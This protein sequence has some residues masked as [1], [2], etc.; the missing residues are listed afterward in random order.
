MRAAGCTRCAHVSSP[1]STARD[2][3]R[4][5]AKASASCLPASRTSAR[6]RCSTRSPEPNSPSSRPI[7]GTTRDKISETIQIDG[8]PLH[9][10]DTAGLREGGDEVERIG[11]ERSWH[12]IEGADAVVLL[13][14]L[15]RRG[16]PA[17]SMPT[18]ASASASPRSPAVRAP[19]LDVW[20]KADIAA[21]P[22]DAL[23]LSATHRRRARPPAPRAA[24]KSRMAQLGRGA[25]HRTRTACAGAAALRAAL[26]Q[27][28]RCS[29]PKRRRWSC[30][31]RSCVPRTR[32]WA[33][34]P[35]HSAPT[36]CSARSSAASASANKTASRAVQW[37]L[38]RP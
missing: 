19:L 37:L 1:C 27:A 9:V 8:V 17:T 18:H 35:A 6:A 23:A 10:V 28:A 15:T 11:I 33:R 38:S 4:C 21:A 20:N 3:A 16:E 14:D 32:R 34:S 22:L 30:W 13:H 24:R 26:L 36:T 2:K 31:P 12:E 5:C 25:V 29:M 7:P